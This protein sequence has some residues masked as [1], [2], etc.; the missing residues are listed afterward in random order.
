M[1]GIGID[2]VDID[3]FRNLITRRP[4][5]R[6]RLFTPGELISLQGQLDDAPSLAARFAVRE[7]TMKALGVGLGAFDFHDVAVH[8]LE[9]GAPVLHVSGRAQALAQAQGVDSWHVSITHTDSVAMAV[10]AAL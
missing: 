2:A 6:A 7:A 9:S 1:K 4:S 10:V 3:R 8:R 5:M